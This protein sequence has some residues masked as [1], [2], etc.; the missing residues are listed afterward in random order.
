MAI[1]DFF[2]FSGFPFGEMNTTVNTEPVVEKQKESKSV[3]EV[4]C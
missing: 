2:T 3:R 1:A 4:C